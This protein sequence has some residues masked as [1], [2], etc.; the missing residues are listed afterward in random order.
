MKDDL[1]QILKNAIE[2]IEKIPTTTILK[3]LETLNIERERFLDLFNFA[4][5]RAVCIVDKNCNPYYYNDLCLK[6]GIMYRDEE[7][8]LMYNSTF[9]DTIKSVIFKVN[10]ERLNYYS[11]NVS[12][13]T[14]EGSSAILGERFFR[15]ECSTK[16]FSEFFVI[17]SDITYESLESINRYQEDSI[18]SLSNVVYG[19]A[20]EIKNPLSAIYLHANVV[21]KMIEKSK[22]DRNYVSTEINI[23]LSEIDRLNRIVNDLMFSLRPY[24]YKEKY[25]NINDIV[26]EVVEVFLPEMREKMISVEIMSD[27][28]IPL[29]L[30][31]RDLIKQVFQNLLKNSIEALSDS[32]GN[33]WVKTYFHSRVDGDFVVVEFKDNGVGIPDEI[34]H[35]IFEPFFTTKENGNGLGLSIVYRIIKAHKGFIDFHSKKNET[36]FRVFLPVSV[37]VRELGYNRKQ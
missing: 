17:I 24:K 32:G 13:G 31:D 7:K 26:K 33:I 15:V 29:V 1:G 4:L 11:V 8:K 12:V 28:S 35:R 34:K 36:V 14:G 16:N 37:G 22:V 20:H 10:E 2:R 25:E 19:I 5:R 6:W 3:L 30:C 23:I 9:L 27:E 21:K 18:A